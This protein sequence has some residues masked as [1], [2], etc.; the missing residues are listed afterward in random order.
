MALEELTPEDA[1]RTHGAHAAPPPP[2][3]VRGVGE[4]LDLG[5]DMLLRRFGTIFGFSVLVLVPLQLMSRQF[6]DAAAEPTPWILLPI[7]GGVVANALITAFV[8]TVVDGELRGGAVSFGAALGHCL[9]RAPALIAVSFL[10][11]LGT[12]LGTLCCIVPG[13]FLMFLW[14]VAP[15]VV[16]VERLGPIAS[17]VRSGRL[18]KPSFFRWAGVMLCVFALGLP[19]SVPVQLLAQPATREIISDFV[20]LSGSTFLAL[21]LLLSSA[22]L[23]VAS[24][25]AG[26]VSTVFYMD[27]RVRHDG[28]D[29]TIRLA[30]MRAG[31]SEELA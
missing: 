23:A 24:G 2:L 26:V 22:F 7:V 28:H 31:V 15:A 20:G 13:I 10:I 5:L 9:R 4:L 8:T 11:G 16:V 19:F 12:F 25:L 1:S 6:I 21:D 30:R 29:F 3:H 18:V 27:C 17:L 14:S